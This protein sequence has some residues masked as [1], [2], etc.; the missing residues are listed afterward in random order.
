M[1][2][3]TTITIKPRQANFLA[4]FE[5]KYGRPATVTR[6]ALLSFRSTWTNGEHGPLG[7]PLRWPAWLTNSSAFTVQRAIYALPWN[8][9]DAFLASASN[10]SQPSTH[11]DAA[12]TATN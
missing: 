12:D 8:E 2:N 1:S 6:K 7:F 4:A 9:Y 5:T 10:G 3:S 11:T